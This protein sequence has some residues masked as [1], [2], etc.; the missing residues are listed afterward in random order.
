MIEYHYE[1][2]FRLSQPNKHT[3]W[4]IDAARHRNHSVAE[5][6][7]IFCGDDYLLDINKRFLQHDYLTDIITFPSDGEDGLAGDIFI[8]VDRVRENAVVFNVAFDEE[9]RRVMIHGVLHLMGH[10]DSTDAER[11]K[12]RKEEDVM[13]ELFHVKHS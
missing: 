2:D 13:L 6:N 8:S 1:T 9:L 11:Q 10:N 12:M 4:I 3:D 5:L 7:Y